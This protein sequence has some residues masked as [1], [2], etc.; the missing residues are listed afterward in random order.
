MGGPGAER[1]ALLASTIGCLVI[2]CVGIAFA[3]LAHSQAILLDGA[4]NL[5]YFVTGIFTLKVARLV[6]QGDDERFPYGYGFFEP[7]ING[8]K[9]FLV[10]G[11]SLMAF[12]DA[13]AVL[14]EGG[15]HIEV[16]VAVWYGAFAVVACSI[17]AA[18]TY[19]GAKRTGSPLVQ[20][21]AKNWI[22]NGAISGAVLV[23]F[24]VAWWLQRNGQDNAAL[25]VD[26]LLVVTVVA[27]SI[28]VPARMAWQAIMELLN[29]TPSQAIADEVKAIVEA[30]LKD[31]PVRRLW[32]RVI[33][34]GRSR[35][36]GVHVQLPGDHALT[37]AQLD[38]VRAKTALALRE[39]YQPITLDMI[40]IGD[41][42]WGGGQTEAVS[43]HG[44]GGER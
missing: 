28:S 16:G 4:F 6:R 11:V 19:R 32:V 37:P 23:S 33:Q 43:D 27:V 22:V 18:I 1:R 44:G 26:P 9:G 15:R 29:R 40:F 25:Y 17:L 35:M 2:G 10:L 13:L 8:V 41:A 39:R 36:V 38:R 42:Y 30:Q 3:A 12:F 20:V 31:L 7:L 21:D 14:F 34:P 24:I 5:T